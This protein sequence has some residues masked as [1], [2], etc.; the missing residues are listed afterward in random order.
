MG[1]R[2]AW[3]AVSR[4]RPHRAGHQSL[5]AS[6]CPHPSPHPQPMAQALPTGFSCF[7]ALCGESSPII[8]T[9]SQLLGNLQQVGE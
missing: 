5:D 8:P 1:S 7:L 2:Q 9:L 4:Y 6:W 3:W